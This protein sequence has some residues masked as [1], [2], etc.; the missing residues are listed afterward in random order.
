MKF[1]GSSSI[2][3]VELD[4]RT[5]YFIIFQKVEHAKLIAKLIL[6]AKDATEE[7]VAR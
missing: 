6:G 4:E 3:S 7:N 2:T 5:T 1:T